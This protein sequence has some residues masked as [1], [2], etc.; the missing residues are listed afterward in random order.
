MPI[1]PK[2]TPT[3]PHIAQTPHRSITQHEHTLAAE[4]EVLRLRR[5]GKSYRKIAALALDPDGDPYFIT[6]AGA[7]KAYRR[8]IRR[9][10]VEPAISARDEAIDECDEILAVWMPIALNPKHELT[11]QANRIV[12]RQQRRRAALTG[13]DM[14]TQHRLTVTDAMQREIEELANDLGLNPDAV[15][16]SHVDDAPAETSA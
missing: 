5:A 15:D 2:S 12:E 1:P 10:N 16:L 8:A 13:A 3:D 14:P 7:Y 9:V 11:I 6:G 4:A